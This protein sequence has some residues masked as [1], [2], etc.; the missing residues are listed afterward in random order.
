MSTPASHSP[1]ILVTGGAG[2]IGSHTCERLLRDGWEVLSVDNF[3]NFYD[4][5]LKRGNIQEIEEGEYR[6][7]FKNYY[8]DIR[9]RAF[10]RDLCLRERPRAV[11]HL[12]AMAGVRPSIENAALY[13]D[14][15]IA[16]TQS[17]LDACV[18]AGIKHVLFASS[19]S[20]YGNNRKVPFSENDIVDFPISPY[21]ATK[22]SGELLCHAYS[23]LYQINIYCLRF[24][25]VYGPRQRPDLAIHKFARMM[26][27]G[28]TIPVFGDGETARD[29]TYV[30]DIVGGICRALE[31]NLSG[32]GNS[33]YEVFNLGGSSPVKLREMI[34]GLEKALGI[35]AR[36]R[37]LEMQAG[38]VVNTWAD[39]SKS[40]RVLGY[41]P[42][43]PFEDGLEKFAGWITKKT[44]KTVLGKPQAISYV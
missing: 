19:S 27:R 20:V 36:I 29:Y 21:A 5:E 1:K 8:A 17:I 22:K 40:G 44:P 12:A 23:H 15:N 7:K 35:P 34:L 26:L 9:D 10:I 13:T 41:N 24:F 6:E 43:T 11:I 2:F 14:V 33:L 38:D 18:D 3:N 16:G 28:E 25:T 32:N 39:I 30:A 31:T 4:P 37:R 42:K